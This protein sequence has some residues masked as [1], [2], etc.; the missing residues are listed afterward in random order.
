MSP[1]FAGAEKARGTSKAKASRIYA[2]FIIINAL[3][4]ISDTE[5]ECE[6]VC[7]E[8]WLKKKSKTWFK[9]RQRNIFDY[10]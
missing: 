10:L 7:I 8:G 4:Q 6:I 5:K 9:A 3:Q 2:N 1:S